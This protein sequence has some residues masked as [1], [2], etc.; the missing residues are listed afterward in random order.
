MRALRLAIALILC[1]SFAVEAEETA[2]KPEALQA[3]AEAK[4]E[5]ETTGELKPPPGF[6]ARKRGDVTVYCRKETPLGSRFPA[7]KCCDQAGLRELRL[8]ELE[9]T[10][11][12]E[13]MKACITGSCSAN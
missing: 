2:A 4:P 9:R 8:A 1:V 10:E 12:L 7:E 6:R 5:A 11:V 13:R 3:T